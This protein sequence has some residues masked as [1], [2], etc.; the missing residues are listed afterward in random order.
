MELT[1]L[2]TIRHGQ[3]GAIWGN[4]LFRLDHQ[5]RC[6]VYDLNRDGF[7]EVGYFRLDRW[8]IIVLAGIEI[9]TDIMDVSIISNKMRY[10]FLSTFF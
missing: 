7:P 9:A 4:L 5:G 6:Y 10:F 3:D 8:E 2:G 1:R